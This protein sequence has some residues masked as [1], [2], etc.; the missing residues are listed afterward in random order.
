MKRG[1]GSQSLAWLW[2][3]PGTLIGLAL[4]LLAR[5]SGGE[6]ERRDGT[7]EVHGGATAGVL[8]AIG[9]GRRIEAIALGHVVLARDAVTLGK[10][11]V[12]ERVHVRQWERWGPLFVPAYLAAS[13]WEGLRGR[14]PYFANR[15]E[16]EAR[17]ADVDATPG[18]V[19]RC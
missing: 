13:L 3:A 17:A 15:F 18:T 8:R 11:R 7:I 1:R 5:A 6:V 14:D 19:D 2:A 4:G 12:H 10:W 9:L 16:R